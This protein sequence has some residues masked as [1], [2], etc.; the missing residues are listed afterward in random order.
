MASVALSTVILLP[1]RQVGCLSASLDRR[2]RHLRRGPGAE[3]AARCG[4]DE[5]RQLAVVPGD[6]LQHRAVLGVH[7]HQLAPALP[8]GLGHQLAGHDQRFLVRERDPL[9]RAERRERG[10]EPGGAHDGVEHDVDVGMRGRLE[11]HLDARSEP[12]SSARR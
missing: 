6:T 8:R 9:A 2:L 12:V 4:Q 7:R 3:R 5:P 10:V 11:Q 1:I